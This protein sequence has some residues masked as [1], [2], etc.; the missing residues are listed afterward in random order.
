MS[1]DERGI[2]NS[3]VVNTA[4]RTNEPKHRQYDIQQRLIDFAVLILEI[5]ELLPNTRSGN[6]IAGQLI[7]CGTSPAANYGEAQAAESRKDFIHK[8]RV[9]LKELR[10]THVW[11]LVINKKRMLSD[12]GKLQAAIIECDELI[13]IFVTSIGTA[14]KKNENG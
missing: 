3:E 2:M 14:K 5:A 4:A 6:H 1:N 8:M 10:E 13:S 9:C 7:R 12:S 11:L